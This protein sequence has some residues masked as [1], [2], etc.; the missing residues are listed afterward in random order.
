MLV[1]AAQFDKFEQLCKIFVMFNVNSGHAGH[2]PHFCLKK[3]LRFPCFPA[4]LLFFY[5]YP[6]ILHVSRR[7]T[8]DLAV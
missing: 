2:L 5:W 8:I 3:C 7:V 1:I 6:L 4:Q